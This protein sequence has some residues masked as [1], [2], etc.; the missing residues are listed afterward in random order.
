MGIGTSPTIAEVAKFIL[1]LG[2]G[3]VDVERGISVNRNVMRDNMTPETIVSLRIIKYYMLANGLT[4]SMWKA[5]LY[6]SIE[7]CE[8]LTIEIFI[9]LGGTKLSFQS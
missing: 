1:T 9:I 8:G 6:R 4:V 3:P 7:E 5:A 2:H